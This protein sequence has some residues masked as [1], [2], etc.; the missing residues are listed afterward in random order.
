MKIIYRDIN[1]GRKGELNIYGCVLMSVKL[2]IAH[3]LLLVSALIDIL[4]SSR[5]Y[6]TPVLMMYTSI[7]RRHS[8]YAALLN[9]VIKYIYD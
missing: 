3:V 7:I 8:D 5:R 2:S 6:A 1:G 9:I 4:A